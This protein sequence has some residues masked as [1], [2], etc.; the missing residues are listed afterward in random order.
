[1]PTVALSIIE[2]RLDAS[3]ALSFAET[4][5]QEARAQAVCTA[6]TTSPRE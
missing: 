2:R 6:T 1:M 5:D 3:H 4:L